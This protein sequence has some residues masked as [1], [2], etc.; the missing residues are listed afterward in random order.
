MYNSLVANNDI[1]GELIR[2]VLTGEIRKTK[3]SLDFWE[4]FHYCEFAAETDWKVY[5]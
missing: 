1:D 4:R 3:C 5:V 2:Q